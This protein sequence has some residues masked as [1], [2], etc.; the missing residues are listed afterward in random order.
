MIDL[1][2][3]DVGVPDS[4]SKCQAVGVSGVRRAGQASEVSIGL[5]ADP[6]DVQLIVVDEPGSVVQAA[7]AY[8]SARHRLADRAALVLAEPPV[9]RSG[10]TL[11]AEVDVTVQAVPGLQQ[12]FA[13]ASGVVEVWPEGAVRV[14][15]GRGGVVV[16]VHGDEWSLVFRLD[17]RVLVVLDA[18]P[19]SVLRID[20]D[21]DWAPEVAGMVDGVL[22]ELDRRAPGGDRYPG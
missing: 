17:G 6:D 12:V 5:P 15:R 9:G 14:A 1:T 22:R 3:A 4:A 2:S 21:R 11:P 10:G 20:R 13:E 8:A 7:P 19:E 16:R 18:L